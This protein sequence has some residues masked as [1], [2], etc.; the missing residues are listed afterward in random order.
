MTASDSPLEQSPTAI[1]PVYTT[2]EP[3]KAILLYE[4][5]LEITQTA[6]VKQGNGSVYF[7]WLPSPNVKFE[8]FSQDSWVPEFDVHQAASLNLLDIGTSVEVSMSSPSYSANQDGEQLYQLSGELSEPIIV[9]SGNS[10]S[11][12][13][14]HLVNTSWSGRVNL[15][16][17]GWSV[18]IDSLPNHTNI[19]KALKSQGG[20]AIT[21][22]GKIERSDQG[23]FTVNQA[24]ELLEAL[25]FFFSFSRGLQTSTILQVGY[26][27]NG[28]EIWKKWDANHYIKPWQDVC[29]CFPDF[30]AQSLSELFPS[31]LRRWQNSIWQEP[32]IYAIHWY[33]ESM[34]QA[35]AVEGS[36]V[37]EQAAFELLSRV[38]IVEDKTL[39]SSNAFE[40]LNGVDKLRHLLSESGIPCT[41]PESLIN[42][43]QL[44]QAWDSADG[45]K[46]LTNI[47]N[48][49][50]HSGKPQ[51]RQKLSQ[52]PSASETK[53]EAW[54]LGLWYLELVL[55]RLFEYQ[56]DYFNRVAYKQRDEENIEPVP[57]ANS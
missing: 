47:R 54:Q 49:I 37:L 45:P 50:V 55:L 51:K 46:V 12:L 16:A 26:N 39:I 22:V 36:I 38:L 31:F 30:N 15:E 35:G 41:V 19:K 17:E 2:D 27:V 1:R 25:R 57:W 9:S 10:L 44:S 42:L 24:E 3:N 5:S 33:M 20:Y 48:A 13:L 40:N 14:F 28:D 56:G 52:M 4:G 29:S 18:A 34:A 43:S 7:E 11:Y 32:I 8:F 21:H 53:G 6:N 23:I